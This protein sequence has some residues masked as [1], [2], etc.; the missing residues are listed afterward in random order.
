[1]TYENRFLFYKTMGNYEHIY[2]S[3]H[4]FYSEFNICHDSH[5]ARICEQN[6]TFVTLFFVLLLP[7]L[8]HRKIV[9]SL[10]VPKDMCSE[11]SSKKKLRKE[12][13]LTRD[14]RDG[15]KGRGCQMNKYIQKQNTAINR[16]FIEFLY[17]RVLYRY[18]VRAIASDS[19][20]NLQMNGH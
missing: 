12:C 6:R 2:H 20:G 4:S 17:A 5:R 14:E 11:R 16:I 1:M 8:A 19:R 13:V 10:N 15:K 7:L 3:V 9:G 18:C